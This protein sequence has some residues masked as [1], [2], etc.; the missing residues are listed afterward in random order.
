MSRAHG[1]SREMSGNVYQDSLTKALNIINNQSGN[2]IKISRG[3]P[4]GRMF[5]D[6]EITHPA[7]DTPDTSRSIKIDFS[8]IEM[9][10]GPVSF[11]Y[12]KGGLVPK[13]KGLE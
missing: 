5:T 12:N 4:K 6:A 13:P 11:N 2:K 8:D 3:N 10:E 1:F 9:P 7:S